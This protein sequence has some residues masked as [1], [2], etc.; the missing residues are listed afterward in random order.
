MGEIM[1]SPKGVKA[2]VPERVNIPCP[3][4]GTLHDLHKIPGN[5]LYITVTEQTIQ[6]M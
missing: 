2:G 1:N 6:H 4:C 3:A 5:Q